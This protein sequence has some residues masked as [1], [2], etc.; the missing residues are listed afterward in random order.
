VLT[1]FTAALL[2]ITTF[3]LGDKSFFITMCLAMRHRRRYVYAGVMAALVIMT[4]FS[5]ALGQ[6]ASLL[7]KAVLHYAS[8][9]LL[10]GFG[11][12]LL[13]EAVKM[14]PECR[15]KTLAL[16]DTSA[17]CLSDAEREAIEAVTEAER[18][19]QK[20][21]PFAICLEAFVLTFVAEWGDRTQFATI[22]LA[23]SNSAVGVTIG[24][25]SGHAIC[26][27]IAVIGGRLIA[28]R[29]SERMITLL[30]GILFLVFAMVDWFEGA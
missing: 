25:I 30:G 16:E 27:L 20:K 10:M 3:E 14:S 19:L 21:T 17:E 1:A 6:F 24:A 4:V 28:G 29:I 23:A 2:L 15:D 7:P 11:F 5:V 13:Y 18:K 22:A 26:S 8:V 12:K 9:L